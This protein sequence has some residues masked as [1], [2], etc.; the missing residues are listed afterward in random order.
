MITQ[1]RLKE[2]LH[3]N[4]DTGIFTWKVKK[5]LRVKVGDIAGTFNEW[6]YSK[7]EIDYKVYNTSKL[8]YLY[9]TG[10][11]PERIGHIDRDPSNYKWN[12]LREVTKYEDSWNRKL[13][14]NNTSNVKGLSIN[15]RASGTKR[16]MCK[17]GKYG[18]TYFKYF[19]LEEK[20]KA[21]EWLKEKREELHGE[22]AN[23]G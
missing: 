17:I 16:W 7:I 20:E 8:A 13:A 18:K 10:I 4:P 2:V 11:M 12:N 1:E 19:K 14:S 22:F 5:A 15:K 23:H 3:Y 6:G 9:M 21:I